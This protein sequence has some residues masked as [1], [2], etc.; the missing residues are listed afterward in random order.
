[1]TSPIR[2]SG[3]LNRGSVGPVSVE[4]HGE[5]GRVLVRQVKDYED[6]PTSW[7][8]FVYELE[9]EISAVAEVGRLIISTRDIFG[10]MKAVN[11]VALILVSAGENDFNPPPAYYQSIIIQEPITKSLI[12]GGNVLVSGFARI[13]TNQPLMAQLIDEQG[14]I[15]GIRLLA[16]TPVEGSSY[17]S[18]MGEIPYK[19]DALTPVRLVVYEDGET[20]SDISHLTSVEIVLG[21]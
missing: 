4:L 2:L 20:I 17:G 1:V 6:S 7:A 15:V 11:S 5:D 14:Q 3:F 18:F 13:H 9:F 12:V 21:P 10:R 16:V 19:I 8:S